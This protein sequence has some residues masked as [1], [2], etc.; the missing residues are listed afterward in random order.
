MY[1]KG[2]DTHTMSMKKAI[3]FLSTLGAIIAFALILYFTFTLSSI[4]LDKA[5]LYTGKELSI[6]SVDGTKINEEYGAIDYSDIPENLKNAF[7]SVEDKRFYKHNGIDGIRLLGAIFYDLKTKSFAQGASTI[8]SQLIKNTHLGNEKTIKRKIQEAKLTLELEKKYTKN[9]IITMYL[10]VLYFGNGI[11]G[12]NQASKV[13]FDKNVSDLSL[14]QCAGLAAVVVAPAKYS[15]LLNYENHVER[16][17]LVLSLMQKEGYISQSDLDNALA[18]NYTISNKKNN[19]YVSYV[20]S[21]IYEASQILKLDEKK[22]K[23]K[24]YTIETYCEVDEQKNLSQ[25]INN[26]DLAKE[27]HNH[28]PSDRIAMVCDNNSQGISAYY[29]TTMIAPQTISRQAGS[30]IKPILSYGCAFEQG[31]LLPDSPILD[32]Y[33]NF[34]GYA[35]KN[36]GNTYLGWTN[37]RNAIATSSNVSAVKV[38]EYTGIENALNFGEKLGLTFNKQDYNLT[39]ALG[40]SGVTI[41]T[42]LGAYSTIARYGKLCK[43]RFI[44]RILDQN[45]NTIY[46]HEVEEKQVIGSDVAYLISDT[47]E[48][49]VQNGTGKKLKALNY[50][51][52]AKTGTVENGLY[53]SDAWCVGY[54]DKL[55]FC[56]WYGNLTMKNES[57][58]DNNVTGGSFP[59]LCAR[60]FLSNNKLR[61]KK[62]EVPKTIKKIDIDLYELNNNNNLLEASEETPLLY[63]K[64]I[65]VGL[66]TKIPLSNTFKCPKI[67]SVDIESIGNIG[68]LIIKLPN[69]FGCEISTVSDTNC[70][71]C[72]TLYPKNSKIEYSFLGEGKIQF[73]IKPFF[74]SEKKRIYGETV[75]SNPMYL[76]D[77]SNFDDFDIFQGL[78]D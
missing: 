3:I 39:S 27:N 49:V 73:V 33:T 25:A 38:M 58:L 2:V 56:F 53:N 5:K 66:Q 22:L 77:R 1:N 46:K 43:P 52:Y 68:K 61:G 41:P 55:S 35:P 54:T 7:I 51:I 17:N 40:S 63:R 69:C 30:V 11:Y 24:N 9:E 70:E 59:T 6:L 26:P 10:N 23:T 57:M 60:Q 31:I 64:S 78:F 72:T 8:S 50:P 45:G 75:Y 76:S 47:L 20:S 16:R 4:T 65:N 62:L 15:P 36:F 44:K 21:T 28:I 19:L 48:A 29:S 32:E 12:V 34:S 13:F 74:D 14:A 37:V 71:N 42:L 67:S 18:E